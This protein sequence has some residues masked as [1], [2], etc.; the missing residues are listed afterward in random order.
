MVKRADDQEEETQM[1]NRNFLIGAFAVGALSL[2]LASVEA[3]ADDFVQHLGPVGPHEPILTEVGNKRVLA[4]YEPDGGRCAVH[5]VVWEK[6]D[7]ETGKT[8]A[9]RVRVRLNPRDVVHIDSDNQKTINLQ[10]GD[11]A[12][13]LALTN[14]GNLI[15][16]QASE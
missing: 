15:T 4:F 13:S 7:V 9:S 6:T 3:A 11:H 16:A 10:C 8:S 5:A 1:H 2:S 12:E 14:G